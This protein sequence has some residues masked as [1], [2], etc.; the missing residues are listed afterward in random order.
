MILPTDKHQAFIRKLTDFQQETIHKALRSIRRECKRQGIEIDHI[1]T[2]NGSEFLNEKTIGSIFEAQVYYTH[3]CAG[4]EKGSIE[5][6][7]KL[8]RRLHP[9]G[10]DFSKVTRK[11]IKTLQEKLTTYP[12]PTQAKKGA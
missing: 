7:N 12:R 4:W 2:D 1:L 11:Q 9:K 5:N 6:L 10:T 8:A 3:A